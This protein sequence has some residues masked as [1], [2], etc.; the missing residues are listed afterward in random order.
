MSFDQD[1]QWQMSSVYESPCD[2]KK[3]WRN[4]IVQANGKGGGGGGEQELTSITFATPSSTRILAVCSSTSTGLPFGSTCSLVK[5][6]Q[7]IHKLVL[8][9]SWR[10][11]FEGMAQLVHAR[12]A[13]QGQCVILRMLIKRYGHGL[14]SLGNAEMLI[15]L[16]RDESI[17]WKKF[18]HVWQCCIDPRTILPGVSWVAQ[19]F[20]HRT[21]LHPAS[22]SKRDCVGDT[23]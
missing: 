1:A 4:S 10:R 21:C 23:A 14:A 19:T 20:C 17:P 22:C 11:S 13:T 12:V 5:C 3:H 2:D 9:A 6:Q 18:E 15:H 7:N 16:A 8:T